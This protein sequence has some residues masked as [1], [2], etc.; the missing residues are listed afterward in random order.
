MIL[1]NAFYK[2]LIGALGTLLFYLLYLLFRYDKFL[3]K[4]FFDFIKSKGNDSFK[5]PHLLLLLLINSPFIWLITFGLMTTIFDW[6][7]MPPEDCAAA[8]IIFP[9]TFC[10]ICF[11][12]YRKSIVH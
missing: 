3:L 6:R 2:G 7:V 12:F 8:A 11:Y 4:S 9:V 5:L 1:L 10:L